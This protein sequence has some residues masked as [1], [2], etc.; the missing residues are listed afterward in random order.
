MTDRAFPAGH[1]LCFPV[2][3]AGGEVSFENGFHYA[4]G[5]YEHHAIDIRG[6]TGMLVVAP[7]AGQVVHSWRYRGETR[8]G[9]GYGATSGHYVLYVDDLG[10]FHFFSHLDQ[11][12][13]VAP[14]ATVIAG[15]ILGFLGAT[16]NAHG[17]PHLHYQVH[18]PLRGRR[19]SEYET[20]EFL[21]SGGDAVNPY[22]EL[23]RLA[24][25]LGATRNAG[26]RYTIPAASPPGAQAPAAP[27][28]P[29]PPR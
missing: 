10:Y 19:A 3:P 26:G 8:P 27:G 11:P 17:V 6:T 24:S 4:R 18:A 16:G 13:R 25:D 14:D 1:L 21:T 12:P 29:A 28:A 20:R 23:G 5:A 2:K 15:Q 7:R 9:S 22:A